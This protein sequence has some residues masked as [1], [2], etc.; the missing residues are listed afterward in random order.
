MNCIFCGKSDG[1]LKML[2]RKGFDTICRSSVTRRDGLHE[3][4][5]VCRL[6]EYRI[7]QNCRTAYNHK[8]NIAKCSRAA[9]VRDDISR[10]TQ[11]GPFSDDGT[12]HQANIG[13]EISVTAL[14]TNDASNDDINLN[15]GAVSEDVSA[16][17]PNSEGKLNSVT[18]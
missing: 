1:E 16:V 4:L 13:A 15:E 17:A 11:Q 18:Q 7:H 12:V 6:T 8:R 5:S 2:T 10:S 3:N 9:S 14:V